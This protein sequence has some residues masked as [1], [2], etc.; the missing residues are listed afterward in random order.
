MN[1]RTYAVTY[2]GLS[3]TAVGV[4]FVSPNGIV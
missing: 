4:L 1:C 3:N 2:S